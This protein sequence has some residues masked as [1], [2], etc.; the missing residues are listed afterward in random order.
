MAVVRDNCS[1]NAATPITTSRSD[2]P[3]FATSDAVLNFQPARYASRKPAS[4]RTTPTPS[5]SVGQFTFLSDAPRAPSRPA[6]DQ[7]TTMKSAV[8]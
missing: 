5:V 2:E 1:S 3:T 7:S 4:M 8:A 6:I